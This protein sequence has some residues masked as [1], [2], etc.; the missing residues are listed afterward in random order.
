MRRTYLL[1][2]L[3]QISGCRPNFAPPSDTTTSDLDSETDVRVAQQPINIVITN[4]T[5]YPKYFVSFIDCDFLGS[6]KA[7]SCYFFR[8]IV[9]WNV[10]NLNRSTLM[11]LLSAAWFAMTS[12]QRSTSY[13]PGDI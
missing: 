11:I 2:C 1:A 8:T 6:G 12:S 13:L 4:E 5:A 3:I 7:E 9:P 10:D